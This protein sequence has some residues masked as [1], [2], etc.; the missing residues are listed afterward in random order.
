MEN[1]MKPELSEQLQYFLAD[2]DTFQADKFLDW[3]LWNTLVQFKIEPIGYN[4]GWLLKRIDP[5]AATESQRIEVIA[6]NFKTVVWQAAQLLA[7]NS[8]P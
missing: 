1:P 4:G 5:V 7:S 8:Q 6:G 2:Y 3:A